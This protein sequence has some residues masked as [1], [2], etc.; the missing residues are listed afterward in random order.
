[1]FLLPFSLLSQQSGYTRTIPSR[2]TSH[3]LISLAR[4][5][6]LTSRIRTKPACLSPPLSTPPSSLRPLTN[7]P[8]PHN[9]K[10]TTANTT[11]SITMVDR[12]K[13]PTAL[14]TTPGL[15]PQAQVNITHSHSRVSAVLPTGESVEI[16]LYGATIISW[17]DGS[18][19]ERLWLSEAAK[20]DG[21]KAVRGGV[22]LVFPV[23]FLFSRAVLVSCGRI[24]R[25]SL[26][27]L[28]HFEREDSRDKLY[29]IGR[30][31][32]QSI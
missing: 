16:L 9:H 32:F 26:V 27:K 6:Y 4:L 23:R 19:E 11:P 21:S 1:M 13:K 2:R 17:K 5:S 3:D 8:P 25:D 28:L 15:P 7:T 10:P 31:T 12:P 24:R 29:K 20:L 18:G 14:A 30:N 22:P